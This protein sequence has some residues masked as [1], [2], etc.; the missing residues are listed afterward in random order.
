VTTELARR[1]QVRQ[2]TL[3]SHVTA[4]DLRYN[5]MLHAAT[6]MLIARGSSA[7][8]A[9]HQAQGLIY[10]MVQREAARELGG[11]GGCN[12]LSP[13]LLDALFQ[14][15]HNRQPLPQLNA[16]TSMVGVADLN[17]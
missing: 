12:R 15:F 3:V 6:G 14:P 7:S 11:S 17:R 9:V 4:F 5:E 13:A 10:G 16:V 8:Q 1:S 2:H